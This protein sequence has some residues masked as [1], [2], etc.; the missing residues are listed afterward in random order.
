[1]K[2]LGK[3]VAC[4]LIMLGLTCTAEETPKQLYEF[5]VTNGETGHFLEAVRLLELA[6]QSDPNNPIISMTLW[7]ATDAS[8][9]K[10]TKEAAIKLFSSIAAGNKR[11]WGLASVHAQVA[12]ELAPSYAL[13]W[14][15]L[16]TVLVQEMSHAKG[17]RE[18]VRYENWA[19]KAY[20]K[21]IDIDPTCSFAHYNLGV[22][23][24]ARGKWEAAHQNFSR[25]TKL[26][27]KPPQELS[28]EIEKRLQKTNKHHGGFFSGLIAPAVLFCKGFSCLGP[29]G[30]AK[31][32]RLFEGTWGQGS[33]MYRFGFIVGVIVILAMVGGGTEA[34]KSRRR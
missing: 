30:G 18:R 13:G 24:A 34:A 11:D 5:A 29:D 1:M 27:L 12:T 26:G 8:D 25:A 2:Q 3:L 20:E 10:I 31:F 21:A 19:I 17:D 23:N 22:A 16:G 6:L 32:S 15:H 28:L 9:A 14:A 7:I 33:G 4:L